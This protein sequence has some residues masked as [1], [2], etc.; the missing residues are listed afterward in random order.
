MQ[1]RSVM[2]ASPHSPGVQRAGVRVADV[3]TEE[4]SEAT[5]EEGEPLGGRGRAVRFLR[6]EWTLAAVGSV[7]LAVVMTW[8]LP[9]YASDLVSGGIKPASIGDPAHTIVD[10]GGDT[11]AQA[12]L[13]A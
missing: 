1:W 9:P 12:W 6:H 8:L 2:L 4:V 10:D 13:I 5:A 7:L 11:A 3:A